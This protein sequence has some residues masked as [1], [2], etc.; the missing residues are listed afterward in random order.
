[1]SQPAAGPSQIAHQQMPVLR[2]REQFRGEG[3][4]SAIAT[5][6]SLDQ[7]PS[8]SGFPQFLPVQMTIEKKKGV[9]GKGSRGRWTEDAPPG[10]RGEA[11]L[12]ST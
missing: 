5:P 6:H 1:M 8:R 4:C 9:C 7:F 2:P 11:L 10:E 3:P 12:Q